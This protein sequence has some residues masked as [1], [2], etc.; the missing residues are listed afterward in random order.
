MLPLRGAAR[1][2]L[3]VVVAVGARRGH[4][5]EAAVRRRR[6]TGDARDN[7]F[8]IISIICFAV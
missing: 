4:S 1:R 5:R 2:T 7:I 6:V 3:A 8:R